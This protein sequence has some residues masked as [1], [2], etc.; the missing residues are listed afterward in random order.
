VFYCYFRDI[1]IYQEERNQ[2]LKQQDDAIKKLEDE[3]FRMFI[4]HQG[5]LDEFA[6]KVKE[7]NDKRKEDIEMIELLKLKL[8][9]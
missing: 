9:A 8:E 2:F 7:E 3:K 6:L 4:K 1:V 5:D